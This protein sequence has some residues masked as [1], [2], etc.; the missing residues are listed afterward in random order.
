[1]KRC[2][3]VFLLMICLL[4]CLAGAEE[5]QPLYAVKDENSLWGYID[6]KGKIVIP[7]TFTWAEDFRGDYALVRLIPEGEPV[8][9]YGYF[10]IVDSSGEWVLPPEYYDVL[11]VSD[12]GD[13]ANGRDAGIYYI[14]NGWSKGRKRAFSIYPPA[15]FPG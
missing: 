15:S 8:E 5:G 14:V 10:G 11:S 2:M 1:M 6:C 3:V 4:P 12:S 13:W 9:E 7:G